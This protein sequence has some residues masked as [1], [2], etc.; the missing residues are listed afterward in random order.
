MKGRLTSTSTS[1]RVSPARERIGKPEPRGLKTQLDRYMLDAR[2]QNFSPKTVDKMELGL[3]LFDDFIGGV[4]DVRRVTGD[5]LRRFILHLQK[6]TRW[7]GRKQGDQRPLAD[8]TIKTYA[9]VVKEFWSWLFKK[10]IIAR[11]PMA[12]VPLPRVGKRLPRVFPEADM[13][14]IMDAANSMRDWA[15]ICIFLDSGPR[16]CEVT[17]DE[18]HPGIYMEDIDFEAGTIRVCGKFLDERPAHI[19]P[20]TIEF[21]RRYCQEERP[22]PIGPDKLFLNEDGTPM[23]KGRVQKVLEALGRKAGLKRRLSPHKLRH[24]KAVLSIKYGSSVEYQRKELCHRHISTTQG[25]LDVCDDDVANA[26]RSY[27]P[28]TNLLKLAK[29]LDMDSPGE[30]AKDEIVLTLALPCLH[31]GQ[32]V[33]TYGPWAYMSQETEDPAG[34]T[35]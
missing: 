28:V 34:R 2:A 22:E 25:Y 23:K 4:T 18:T 32:S 1:R 10:R 29:G 33:H 5:D 13:L 19:V 14:A 24:T 35:A 3:R 15:L 7:P 31:A 27:S 6:R 11:N 21:I 30:P 8:E 26:H 20:E 12:D 17:G 9:R 16:L